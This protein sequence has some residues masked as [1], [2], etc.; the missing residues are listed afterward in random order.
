LATPTPMIEPI[1]SV[2]ARETERPGAE[3]PQDR[4]DQEREDHGEV[5]IAA[6]LQ[7]QLDR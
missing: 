7:D 6:D 2:R 4:R 3:I 5:G 1:K